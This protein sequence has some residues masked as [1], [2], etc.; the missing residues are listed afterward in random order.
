MR[1]TESGAFRSVAWGAGWLLLALAAMVAFGTGASA[2]S[3]GD[4][5]V[6]RLTIEVIVGAESAV[7]LE[8]VV[9]SSQPGC[10]N[11]VRTITDDDEQYSF[12]RF[13]VDLGP[14]DADGGFVTFDDDGDLCEYTLTMP[15]LP[16]SFIAPAAQTF[17]FDEVFAVRRTVFIMDREF[18][19]SIGYK[20]YVPGSIGDDLL[21]AEWQLDIRSA[22]A[23]CTNKTVSVPRGDREEILLLGGEAAVAE[24]PSVSRG[25]IDGVIVVA[26][27]ETFCKYELS[28]TGLPDG[29]QQPTGYTVGFASNLPR[30]GGFTTYPADAR[31][32]IYIDKDVNGDASDM[33]AAWEFEL[34]SSQPGCS[35]MSLAV[36]TSGA[37]SVVGSFVDVA[38]R[39][40]AGE[41][42]E[43]QITEVELPDRWY[44]PGPVNVL[45]LDDLTG[46][47]FLSN[48]VLASATAEITLA[49]GTRPEADRAPEFYDYEFTSTC[50]S[51][52]LSVRIASAGTALR[53]LEQLDREP[54][55][56]LEVPLFDA[57]GAPC[58]YVLVDEPLVYSYAS[59]G[60]P[61]PSPREFTL[62]PQSPQWPLVYDYRFG[63]DPADFR[64]AQVAQRLNVYTN[65]LEP[66]AVWT[67]DLSSEQPGCSNRTLT[68][69]GPAVAS[70]NGYSTAVVPDIQWVDDAGD[71]CEYVIVGVDLPSN[72]TPIAPQEF[73][74]ISR[75]LSELNFAFVDPAVSE[76]INFTSYLIGGSDLPES[77]TIELT[78]EQPGCTTQD[79]VVVV[80]VQIENRLHFD[81]VASFDDTGRFCEYTLT[82]TD[83]PDDWFSFSELFSF[84]PSG[85]AVYSNERPNLFN[86]L[87]GAGTTI[88][89]AKEVVGDL[90]DLPATWDFELTSDQAGCSNEVLSIPSDAAERVQGAFVDLA[91]F[92]ADGRECR[93]V[94]AEINLSDPWPP[95]EPQA[96]S[97][98]DDRFGQVAFTNTAIAE[99]PP[100]DEDEPPVD[101][102]FYGSYPS[103]PSEP[104]E[105]IATPTVV[106]AVA[107]TAIAPAPAALAPVIVTAAAPTPV[108]ITAVAQTPAITGGT[109][110]FSNALPTTHLAAGGSPKE[111][112]LTGSESHAPL[113][114]AAMLMLAGVFFLALSKA[115]RR[116]R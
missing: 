38:P 27:A 48:A 79:S 2:Q 113:N 5:P 51:G 109:Y 7:G 1:W 95:T 53:N 18:R 96:A 106:P 90:S 15:N 101:E 28:L 61:G 93:Y 114:L 60:R 80:N 98:R 72:V 66:P 78:S 13:F 88:T 23:E 91:E 99:A 86:R 110:R 31:P 62:D 47:A 76:R 20:V 57:A 46:Y 41:F 87:D 12:G 17:N 107:P 54:I 56:V 64:D 55:E 11:R 42:C 29:W 116:R 85:K 30:R 74:F 71:W 45:R 14:F 3:D 35:N 16:S 50:L 65:V 84:D 102:P 68:V 6:G 94:I 108:V 115:P 77:M 81:G 36:P 104:V 58:T 22:Q 19:E 37:D 32:T 40:D 4:S 10:T 83:L 73:S 21:P 44:Q 89:V 67:F 63:H 97:M 39:D 92:D 82:Q 25:E 33:P 75:I 34:T 9:S 49:V 24:P 105:P 43:Y 59:P 70:G 8:F 111:L 26:G 103:Y 52:P 112:A 69:D 100:V